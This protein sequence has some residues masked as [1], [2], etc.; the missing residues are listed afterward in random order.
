MEGI[1]LVSSRRTGERKQ[2]LLNCFASVCFFFFFFCFPQH[3]RVFHLFRI[4]EAI[5][6]HPI[7]V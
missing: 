7:G 5:N 4:P 6:L 3:H 1:P 2:G